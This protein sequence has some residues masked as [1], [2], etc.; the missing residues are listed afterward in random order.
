MF[1]VFG[2]FALLPDRM[3]AQT[4]FAMAVA[5]LL[6]A[7]IIRCLIVPAVLRLLG[8][9]AWWLS[10]VLSRRIPPASTSRAA[11]TRT[12]RPTGPPA[13]DHPTVTPWASTCSGFSWRTEADRII[14]PHNRPERPEEFLMRSARPKSSRCAHSPSNTR[15]SRF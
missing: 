3:L 14:G 15:H 2:S 12:R 7:V 6:D 5:V 1:A 9:R 8:A 11:E 10:G 4:G 13:G